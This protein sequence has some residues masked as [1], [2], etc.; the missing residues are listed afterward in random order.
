MRVF[1]EE[2][3]VLEML[4]LEWYLLQNYVQIFS[5]TEAFISARTARCPY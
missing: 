3:S 1:D 5:I 2:V 4:V